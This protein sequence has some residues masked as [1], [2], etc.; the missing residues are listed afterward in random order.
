LAKKQGCDGHIAPVTVNDIIE[1][2]QRKYYM[3]EAI[4]RRPSLSDAAVILKKNEG[5]LLL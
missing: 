4:K 3:R 2:E 5:S 1:Q